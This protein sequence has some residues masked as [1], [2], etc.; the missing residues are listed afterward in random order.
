MSKNKKK[1]YADIYADAKEKKLEED[2]RKLYEECER[3]IE[4]KLEAHF[5]K[6]TEKDKKWRKK[7]ENG[8]IT[9]AEYKRWVEGQIYQGKMWAQRKEIIAQQLYDFNKVAYEL[10]N[11]EIPDIFANDFNYMAYELENQVNVDF[12]FMIYDP[13][14]IRKLMVED[15]D[16][17]PYKKLNKEKDIAW[18]FKNIKRETAKSIIEGES[19]DK[20]AERLAREVTNR[21][22]KEMMKHART[23]TNSTRNQARDTRIKHGIKLGLDIQKE[24][25]ATLDERTRTAHGHLDGVKVPYDADFEVAGMKIKYPGDP[26]AHPSLVYNCRCTLEGNVGGYPDSFD[27]RRDNSTGEIVRKMSY[28]EWYKEKTGKDLPEAKKPKKRKKNR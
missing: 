1:T 9:E 20:L 24:W 3:D 6:F 25:S 18:N 4:R 22:K 21:N 7:L 28:K 10:I 5:A 16:I 26:H 2:L 11:N 15:V 19:V 12:G 8:E 14:T 13:V 17:L 27:I 23:I